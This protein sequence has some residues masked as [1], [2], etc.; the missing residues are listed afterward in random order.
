MRSFH[1]TSCSCAL[2]AGGSGPGCLTYSWSH[3]PKLSASQDTLVWPMT[4]QT[5]WPAQAVA[6]GPALLELGLMYEHMRQRCIPDGA[7]PNAA[8]LRAACGGPCS[9]AL[10]AADARPTPGCPSSGV[11]LSVFFT[12]ALSTS[13]ASSALG[14]FILF[15]AISS[16]TAFAAPF[17]GFFT[18]RFL[19]G[20]DSGAKAISSSVFSIS[21]CR[22]RGHRSSGLCILHPT[23]W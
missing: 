10:S 4:L 15:L 8:L 16:I 12:V 18:R 21:P 22:H 19:L 23:D 1:M 5:F 14:L 20:G 13:S 7:G 6:P 3:M 17:S 2:V 9:P 11:L